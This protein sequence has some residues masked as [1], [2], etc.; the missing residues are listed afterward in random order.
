[1]NLLLSILLYLGT[2]SPNNTYMMA[3]I[4]LYLSQQENNISTVQQDIMLT[5]QI[6]NEYGGQAHAIDIPDATIEH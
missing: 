2:I 6:Q 4:N 5:Q 1:M 3:Q